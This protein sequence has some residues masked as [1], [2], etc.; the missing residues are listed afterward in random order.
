VPVVG[1]RVAA[2]RRECVPEVG[3]RVAATRRECVPEV[4]R[5]VELRPNLERR[6]PTACSA[7]HCGMRSRILPVVRRCSNASCA[8]LAS[9]NGRTRPILGCILPAATSSNSCAP[10]AARLHGPS[11]SIQSNLATG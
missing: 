4:G 1:R 8:S 6:C 5:R 10:S 11:A 2:T 7:A 3:R 9:L